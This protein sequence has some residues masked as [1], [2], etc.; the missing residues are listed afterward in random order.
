MTTDLS[1]SERERYASQIEGDLGVE[2]QIR[3]KQSRAMVVGAGAV[4][5][6]AAA[7]LVSCGVGYVAVVD[8]GSVTLTDLAGQALYYTPDVGES[9][10]DTVAGKLGLLNPEVQVES[11]PVHLEA[12]NAAAIVD[13]HD[14]VLDCTHDA[15]A[16]DALD[17]SG[18]TVLRVTE[19]QIGASPAAE[20]IGLLARAVVEARP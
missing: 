10:A 12:A 16:A 2:G 11:Y 3:L 6:A 1:D 18:A 14:L 15:A 8:G 13:G 17:S 5:A 20:A 9:K 19:G 7:E 4:G